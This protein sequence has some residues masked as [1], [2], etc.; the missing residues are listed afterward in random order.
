MGGKQP[1]MSARIG[2][3]EHDET[4]EPVTARHHLRSFRGPNHED[5]EVEARSFLSAQVCMG[6]RIS[7]CIL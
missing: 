7:R 3:W 4:N 6:K 2:C 1:N 5:G